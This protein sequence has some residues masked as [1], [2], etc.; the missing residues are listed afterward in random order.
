MNDYDNVSKH[1]L[2]LIKQPKSPKI[3]FIAKKFT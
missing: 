2:S 3:P 1:D